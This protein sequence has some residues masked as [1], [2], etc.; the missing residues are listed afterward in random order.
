MELHED[1]TVY[2]LTSKSGHFV[3]AM[4]LTS[5]LEWSYAFTTPEKAKDFLR[6]ARQQGFLENVN[7]LFP[8]TLAEWFRMQE[9]QNLPDLAIDP[10]PEQHRDH[11]TFASFK[12]STTLPLS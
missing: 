6:M 8:C 2:V 12:P 1:T 5:G 4:E 10:D 9:D 7:R 11:P 3:G